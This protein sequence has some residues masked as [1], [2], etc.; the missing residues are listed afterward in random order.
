MSNP[1]DV[2]LVVRVAVVEG[3]ELAPL[4]LK[5]ACLHPPLY[6]PKT[7]PELI[8]GGRGVQTEQVRV[9]QDSKER[10]L[11]SHQTCNPALD[12]VLSDQYLVL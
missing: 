8:I 3:H 2:G 10:I 5:W 11:S 1:L 7:V 9:T 4:S 6:L 12:L